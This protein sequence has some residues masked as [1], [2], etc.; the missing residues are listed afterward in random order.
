MGRT[1]TSPGGGTVSIASFGYD[2]GGRTTS[3]GIAAVS[4]HLVLAPQFQ[5]RTDRTTHM[6]KEFMIHLCS[7]HLSFDPLE[8]EARQDG[9]SV[10]RLDLSDLSDQAA[11][12]RYLSF[13][14]MFPHEILG[15]DAAIDLMSDLEW[16]GNDQ[17]YLVLILASAA[18]KSVTAD[19]VSMLPDVVD[20][21][22]SGEDVP[23]VVYCDVDS[24]RVQRV[25]AARNRALT[26]AGRLPWVHP[27]TGPVDVVVH[28]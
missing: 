13:E 17:G 12:V 9:M 6:N 11:L 26:K 4:V 2:A 24:G 18:K 25:L 7:D 8:S 20:R 3:R 22:R 27:D 21:W 1:M 5:A 28:G 14:L 10:I 15:L 19:M 23:F 16:F